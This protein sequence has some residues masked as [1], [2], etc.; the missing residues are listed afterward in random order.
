MGRVCP[1]LRLTMVILNEL[2]VRREGICLR[3]G[4][5]DGGVNGKRGKTV[6]CKIMKDVCFH[7]SEGTSREGGERDYLK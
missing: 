3:T 1:P 5:D 4:R 7:V 6:M 2:L